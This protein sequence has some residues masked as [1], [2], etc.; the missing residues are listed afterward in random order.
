MRTELSPWFCEEL[1]EV[2]APWAYE[3]K[4]QPFR[5]VAS[6]EA[7][8]ALYGIMIMS[9]GA[10]GKNGIREAPDGRCR[11]PI[12]TYHERGWRATGRWRETT[13]CGLKFASGVEG[14]DCRQLD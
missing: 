2:S 3:A 14:A 10:W 7:L 13:D 5:L 6:L 12:T 9:H 4:G 1:D 11:A 8:A